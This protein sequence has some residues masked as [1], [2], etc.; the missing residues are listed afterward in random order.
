MLD[1]ITCC[2]IC[3]SLDIEKNK[4][5]VFKA[6]EGAGASGSFFFFSYNNRFIIK[7]MTKPELK[8]LLD[9]LPSYVDHV[10]KS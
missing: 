6:G 5:R 8:V 1:K 2:D 7:T 10:K 4:N 3:K 9:I